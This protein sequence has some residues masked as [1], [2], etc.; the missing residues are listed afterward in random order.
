MVVVDA[1][2]LERCK[3]GG[4]T[5]M[6]ENHSSNLSFFRRNK[7]AIT[8]AAVAD[9]NKGFLLWPNNGSRWQAEKLGEMAS[10]ALLFVCD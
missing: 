1:V 2:R 5:K 4:Q 8:R 7:Q 10:R 3:A 6:P 9:S